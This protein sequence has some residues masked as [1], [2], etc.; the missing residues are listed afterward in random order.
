MTKE[1]KPKVNNGLNTNKNSQVATVRDWLTSDA[2]KEQLRLAAPEMMDV[3]RLIRIVF[4]QIRRNPKLMEC[5]RESLMACVMGCAQLGLEPEPFLGQAYLVPYGKE[6]TLI[7]GYR[8]YIA[9]ARRSGEVKSVTAQAVH[10]NDTFEL[11]YGVPEDKLRHVPAIG[12]RG[13]FVGAY[14][15]FRYKDGSYSFDYMPKEDIDK[16]RKRSKASSSGP[17]VTDYEEM[18]KK[19]VIRRHIKIAPLSVELRKAAAAEDVLAAGE[20]QVNIFSDENDFK[21]VFEQETEWACPPFSIH[22]K[23]GNDTTEE[24]V[25]NKKGEEVYVF[26]PNKQ[27]RVATSVCQKCKNKEGCPAI[28]ELEEDSENKTK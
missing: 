23:T 7:P 14:V 10:E 11:V 1:I 4:T 5:T 21:E 9:L 26:C 22:K 13:D 25:K 17:W 8:G 3:N 28:D 6:C 16:I 2:F 20:S 24:N 15:V 12:K 27:Q 19:T 18:A